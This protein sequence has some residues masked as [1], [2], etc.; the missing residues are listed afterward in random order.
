MVESGDFWANVTKKYWFSGPTVRNQPSNNCLLTP[1]SRDHIEKNLV[2]TLPDSF[3]WILQYFAS[4]AHVTSKELLQ[5]LADIE[6][7]ILHL[8]QDYFGY[9]KGVKT[10][11]RDKWSSKYIKDGVHQCPRCDFDF[12]GKKKLEDHIQHAHAPA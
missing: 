3:A 1:T 11:K 9:F 12:Q 4:Y 6:N 7:L 2:T 10:P 8:N 5:E